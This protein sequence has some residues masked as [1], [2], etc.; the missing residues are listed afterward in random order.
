MRK[1]ESA[2]AILVCVFSCGCVT[3]DPARQCSWR[4]EA[5]ATFV[6]PYSK[7]SFPTSLGNFRRVDIHNYDQQGKDVSVG[8]N[9]PSPVA[10]TVYVY[11]GPSDFAIM[12]A[13]KS[14]SASEAVLDQHFQ[15]CEQDVLNNHRDAK[16]LTQ[17]KCKLIQ[18]E[19]QFEGRKAVFSMSYQFG[20]TSQE[21]VS[22]LYVF[23]I[24]PGVKFLLTERQ[25]VK[26]RFT[27]LA[28]EKPKAEA[29]VAAFMGD[30]IWP[31][32]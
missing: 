19:N 11:P 29:E 8:Y 22:E 4:N 1:F 21:S 24:E 18:G 30:L 3:T 32:K 16:L 7:F 27:Y 28:A 13:P 2:L 15:M 31:T 25:F 10:A 5:S 12:P 9:S 23:V 17:V 20:F 26:Y 14:M 6:H